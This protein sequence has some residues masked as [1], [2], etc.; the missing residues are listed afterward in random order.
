MLPPD[1]G[2]AFL[3]LTNVFGNQ[4]NVDEIASVSSV[5]LVFNMTVPVEENSTTGFNQLSSATSI[6]SGITSELVF[7]EEALARAKKSVL[8]SLDTTEALKTSLF[9]TVRTS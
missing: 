3:A 5:E 8:A 6:F 2:L 9:W 4:A 7:D 1:L